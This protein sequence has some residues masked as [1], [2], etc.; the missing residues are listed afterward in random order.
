VTFRDNILLSLLS[1][2]SL[3]LEMASKKP[4]KAPKSIA[5]LDHW[6]QSTIAILPTQV[7]HLAEQVLKFPV[8]PL[9]VPWR[10]LTL[11]PQILLKLGQQE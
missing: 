1:V 11:L 5:D 3:S 10:V 7:D 4:G 9:V 6:L 2:K 8:I